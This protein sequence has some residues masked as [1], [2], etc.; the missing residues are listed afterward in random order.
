MA[1]G[2]DLVSAMLAKLGRLGSGDT[3]A[4]QELIDYL[5]E[6]NRMI[7]TWNS[8]LGPVFF[9]TLDTLTWTAGQASQTIGAGGDFAVGRPLEII[10]AHY[11]DSSNVDYALSL[12]THREYQE[13]TT[14][15]IQTTFPSYL[16]Y[17]QTIAS[18][19]G[20]L[21]IWPVPQDAAT[22][23]LNSKKE[24][25][26]MTSSTVT[27]PPGWEDAVVNNGAM[28]LSDMVGGNPTQ[29]L[30]EAADESYRA[31]VQAAIHPNLAKLDPLL[32]G[33]SR[34]HNPRA[35]WNI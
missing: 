29:V 32:P 16:A 13:I 24:V 12:I 18:G 10:S 20:T 26:A 2:N 15:E 31:I 21:F 17:N 28:R 1:T 25:S 22:I 14:K 11:R 3:A 34:G 4:A 6:V 9:E 35:Y 33:Q 30:A 7:G 19:L 8:Q 5:A 27:L 23:R